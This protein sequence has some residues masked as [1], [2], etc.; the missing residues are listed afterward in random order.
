MTDHIL[1]EFDNDLKGLH[2]LLASMSAHVEEQMRET[3]QLLKDPHLELVDSVLAKATNVNRMEIRIDRTCARILARHHPLASDLRTIITAQKVIADIER[4]GD[5]CERIAKSVND[6]LEEGF[7]AGQM[8]DNLVGLAGLVSQ[9]V[10]GSIDSYLRVD[11]DGARQVISGDQAIDECYAEILGQ[12]S[13]RL[14]KSEAGVE[15]VAME[16]LWVVRSLERIGDHSCNVAEYAIY[17]DEG[18]D[19]RHKGKLNPGD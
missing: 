8:P 11:T 10:R 14:K 19:V 15:A 18:K 5:E 12:I 3:E 13:E 6:R 9:S 7:D 2:E 17:L 4:I 16:W 1:T